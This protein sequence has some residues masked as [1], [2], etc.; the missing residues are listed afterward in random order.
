MPSQKVK[1][2]NP[3]VDELVLGV[4][5]DTIECLQTIHLHQIWELY[6]SEFPNVQEMPPLT[7]RFETFDDAGRDSVSEMEVN[8]LP[9]LRRLWFSSDD[10]QH[11]VQFQHDRF[12]FN[13]RK[14]HDQNV[15]PSFDILLP[16][17]EREFQRLK[18]FVNKNFEIQ[19]EI[20]QAEVAYINIMQRSDFQKMSHFQLIIDDDSLEIEGMQLFVGEILRDDS[21]KPFARLIYEM[22]SP[23][24]Q[25]SGTPSHRLGLTVR[26]GPAGTD[27]SSVRA[28]MEMAHS[29]IISQFLKLTSDNAQKFWGKSEG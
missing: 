4:Q 19:L 11:L 9:P 16:I 10:E 14:R 18:D 21:D 22:Q 23:I 1:F 5:F 8:P 26:G 2:T 17:F 28:F 25:D 24:K 15:Y 6:K 29:R 12:I 3:P 27:L 13:W 7:P 20:N